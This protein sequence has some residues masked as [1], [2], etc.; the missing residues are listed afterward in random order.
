M[1]KSNVILTAVVLVASAFLLWLWYFLG[2]NKVDSPL[3]LVMSVI[4][5]VIVAVGVALVAK[6]EKT[7]REKVRTVYVGPNKLYNSESG[8]LTLANGVSATESAAAVL[9]SLEYDFDRADAPDPKD[10]ENP[11]KWTHVVR[12]SKFEPAKDD[13]QGNG[14]AGQSASQSSSQSAGQRS[15]TWEGEVVIVETGRAVPFSSRE[16]LAT[17]IG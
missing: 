12:T 10:E 3:D 5:W 4:W 13:D 7:R 14:V 9:A 11:I 8:V 2:F 6:V 1:K 16:E 17:I 15:E